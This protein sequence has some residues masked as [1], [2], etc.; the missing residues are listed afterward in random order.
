V[1]TIAVYW[2][3]KIKIYGFNEVTDLALIGFTL[4]PKQMAPVGCILKDLEEPNIRILLV[5]GQYLDDGKL[6]LYLLIEKRW[7]ERMIKHL[8]QLT[9]GDIGESIHITS[10]TGLIYF[11]G[12]HFGDRY[13]IADSAFGVLAKNGIPIL[14]SACSAASIYLVLHEEK[15]ENAKEVLSEAFQLPK[16]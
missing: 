10:P 8:R 9:G 4:P 11:H 7:E 14:A 13:G 16:T 3:P 2:E 12:P 5:L 15:L 1:E 6:S